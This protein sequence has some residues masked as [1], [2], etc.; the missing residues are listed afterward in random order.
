MSACGSSST[1]STSTALNTQRVAGSIEQS[2]LSERH[3][4]VTVECPVSEPQEAGKTFTCIATGK[5]AKG[6]AIRTPFKVTVQNSKGYV[7]YVGE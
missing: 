2:V 5:N 1:S 6:G 3:L 7:T 4:H